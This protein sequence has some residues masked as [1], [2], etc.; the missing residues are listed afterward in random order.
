MDDD[1]HPSSLSPGGTPLPAR[2]DLENVQPQDVDKLP[3]EMPNDWHIELRYLPI[4]PYAHA[5]LALVDPSGT[6]QRELHGLARSR[7][8][9]ELVPMGMDGAHL[10]GVQ[11][12]RRYFGDSTQRIATVYSGPYDDAVRGKWRSGLQAAVDMNK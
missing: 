4:G 7:N 8:T 9:G 1:N 10:V 12:D 11:P 6:T 3:A 5:Y 2:K